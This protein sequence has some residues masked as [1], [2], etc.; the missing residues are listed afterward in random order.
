MLTAAR[1]TLSRRGA[2]RLGPLLALCWLLAGCAAPGPLLER[3][4]P[5]PQWPDAPF[6]AR[7]EWVKSVASPEDAGIGKPFWKKALE[8]ITGADQHQINRP[9]G[10]LYDDAGRLVIA[11]PGSSVV[12]V[13]DTR[14]GRYL[15]LRGTK[16]SA[17]RSP[18]ALA[19]D[20]AGLLYITDSSTNTVYRYDFVSGALTTFITGLQRPTGIAF[21]PVNGLLYLSETMAHRVI[22][23]DLS[24]KVRYR[25]GDKS[26]A[27]DGALNLPTDLAVDAKGKVYVTDPL[28]FKIRIYTPEG[29]ALSQFGVMGDAHG[30]LNKPKGIAVDSEGRIL[31]CDA[32]LDAVQLFN[33]KGQFLFSFGT[34]GAQAGGLWLPSGLSI[35]NNFVFVA[36]TFNQRI[37]VF[38]LLPK[39]PAEPMDAGEK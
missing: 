13:M 38:R 36:D 6:P 27:Q 39:G 31:V 25:F 18:I 17:F 21:N 37:Q 3:S 15:R 30:E 29:T 22:A 16:G 19:E 7:V 35:H 33:E 24:G 20:A 2:L 5:G 11:D 26:P 9:Y 12:H 10:I 28:N 8:L 1:R 34:A 4:Q 32:L 23:V 14:E